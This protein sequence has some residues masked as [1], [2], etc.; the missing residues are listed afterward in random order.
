[1]FNTLYVPL[2][3][4]VPLK[5][6]SSEMDPAKIRLIAKFFRKNPSVPIMWDPFKFTA[7]SRTV[8]GNYAPNGQLQ[9]KA[10]TAPTAPLILHRTRNGKCAL[11]LLGIS[12][13]CRNEHVLIVINRFHLWKPRWMLHVFVNWAIVLIKLLHFLIFQL[14]KVEQRPLHTCQLWRGRVFE[15]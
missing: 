5:V 6:L 3:H 12:C 7:P 14:P 11:K 4:L 2:K 9:S 13:Q 15:A 1:M 8:I 10:H